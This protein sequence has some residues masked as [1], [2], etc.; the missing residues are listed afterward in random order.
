MLRHSDEHPVP[1]PSTYAE[2]HI[3]DEWRPYELKTV[4][5]EQCLA[6]PERLT[7]CTTVDVCA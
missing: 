3:P 5:H 1:P 4:S 7:A 6:Q 2:P